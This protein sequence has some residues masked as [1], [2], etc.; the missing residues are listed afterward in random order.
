[1]VSFGANL[2]LFLG[3]SVFYN[4]SLK[5]ENYL[6]SSSKYKKQQSS[7]VLSTARVRKGQNGGG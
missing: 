2:I 1:M 3:L 7:V 4:F 5:S 6:C